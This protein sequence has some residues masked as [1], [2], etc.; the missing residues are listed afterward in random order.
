MPIDGL[1]SIQAENK[2]V[3]RPTGAEFDGMVIIIENIEPI[4]DK[5]EFKAGEAIGKASRMSVCK[6]NFIH[7]SIRR[8]HY[9]NNGYIDPSPFLDRFL[10]R[11]KWVQECNDYGIM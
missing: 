11:P 5:N 3:I 7:V 8:K 6:S 9:E 4:R 2:V 1:V 10:P